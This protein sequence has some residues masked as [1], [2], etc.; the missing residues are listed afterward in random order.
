[1]EFPFRDG[2]QFAGLGDC[3]SRQAQALHF[4]WNMALHSVSVAR[5]SQ[6]MN[7]RAGPLVFSMEDEKRR[8]Y[9]EFF[10]D[11]ILSLLPGDLTCEK[12]APQ[13]A[14]LLLLGVKAA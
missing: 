8:A 3:Q 11:R 7:Q 2:K 10:A 14:D 5:A 6:L 4:H 12:F 9:N 13:I 1:M